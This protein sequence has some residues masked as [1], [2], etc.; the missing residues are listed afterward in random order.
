MI[1]HFLAVFL[2]TLF[3]PIGLSEA[4]QK[5]KGA[6]RVTG[7]SCLEFA[8]AKRQVEGKSVGQDECVIISEEAVFNAGGDRFQHLELR[9]SGTVEGWA[10]KEGPRFNYFND[11]PDF[12]YIQ[13][14]NTGQRFKGIA[15]YQG[16]T[17]HGISLFF[18]ENPARWNGKLFVTAHGAGAYGAAGALLPRDPNA[19]FNPLTGVNRYVGLMMDKGYA[20]AHTMRSSQQA[21]GDVAVTLEDGTTLPKYNVSTH[22]GFMIGL[23]KTAENLLQKRLGRKPQRTYFYGFSAGGFLGRLLQYQP[24]FNRDE[25]GTSFFD[26]LLLDD[27]GGGM[28]LPVLMAGGKDTLFVDDADKKRFVKQ[29][30]ITHQ[31]YAGDTDGYLKKKRDNALILKKKG[32]GN[33][34]RMYEVRGVS[35]FDAGQVSRPDLVPQSLDLGGL[36]DSFIDILDRW[37]ETGKEP[38][39]T[40]SDLPVLGD[41][42]GDGKNENPAVAL[43]ETACPLGVYHIFPAAHGR[44][45]RSGQETAFAA[46][47]GTN[48]EPIDGRGEFVDMNGNGRRDRR[49]SV[50]QA[51]ARLGLLK[52]GEKLTPGKYVA[53]VANAAARLAE[54]GLLPQKVVSYYVRKAAATTVREA[55]SN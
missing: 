52:P 31:L 55:E 9:V 19:D 47:D 27:A 10:A 37:V 42:D 46:F 20:V 21:G 38:P 15:R 40:K 3:V 18:P 8:P 44:S 53:C 49:E 36:V 33:S 30:D 26:G 1:L 23:T 13:S 35:H 29:I 6:S 7:P 12:V 14:G 54:E 4:Q 51:W 41:N 48:L 11:A 25:D 28:W 22:A 45:R 16:S 17:G 2:F 24:G 43:P 5:G 50:A 34:H 32:L 39:A